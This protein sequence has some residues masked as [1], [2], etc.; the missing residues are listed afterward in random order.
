MPGQRYERAVRLRSVTVS[1][2]LT[3]QVA[4]LATSSR[5]VHLASEPLT[6]AVAAGSMEATA[7]VFGDAPTVTDGPGV[8]VGDGPGDVGPPVGETTDNGRGDPAATDAEEP[9]LGVPSCPVQM[10]ATAPP[11]RS[12]A[13]VSAT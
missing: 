5:G 11:S 4:S 3:S 8:T 13:R 10:A 1:V 6:R 12:T 7:F 2:S 9:A